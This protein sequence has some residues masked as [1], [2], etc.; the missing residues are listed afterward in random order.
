MR[1]RD[2]TRANLTA[3]STF[4]C[5][6]TSRSTTAVQPAWVYFYNAPWGAPSHCLGDYLQHLNAGADPAAITDAAP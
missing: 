1:S 4:A 3:A 2:S 5:G 6:Q